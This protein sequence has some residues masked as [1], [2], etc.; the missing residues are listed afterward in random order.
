MDKLLESYKSLAYL[1]TQVLFFIEVHKTYSENEELL[2]K[3]KFKDHYA[4]IPF[5]KGISGSL[6]NYSIIIANSFFDEYNKEFTSSKHLEYRDRINRL[7]KITKPVLKRI[8]KWTN[9][10]DYRNYILAHSFRFKD[11]SF[12][13]NDFK[14]FKFNVPHTNSEIILLAN[15]MKVVT[16][17]IAQEFPELATNTTMTE[18]I[19]SKMDFDW[20]EVD[21]DKELETIWTQINIVKEQL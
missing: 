13:D 7:K 9:F 14:P 18:N 15:L 5:A 16:S 20:N 17:C 12:F 2:N 19:L 6:L 4:N 1:A 10:K 3:I 21:I 11:K 8:S